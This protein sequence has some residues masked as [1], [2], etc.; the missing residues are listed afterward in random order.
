MCLDQSQLKGTLAWEKCL[1]Q[2]QFKGTLAREKRTQSRHQRKGNIFYIF[3][4]INI[5]QQLLP[6][7]SVRILVLFPNRK[8][9]VCDTD[10]H[11]ITNGPNPK[12]DGIRIGHLRS[13]PARKLQI[14]SYI[15]SP[16]TVPLKF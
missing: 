3:K 13:N 14:Y 15:F 8:E 2:R 4:V 9:F 6:A 7:S 16:T 12:T 1:D 10:M 11:L 5:F